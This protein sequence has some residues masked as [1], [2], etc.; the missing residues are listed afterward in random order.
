MQV[1]ENVSIL[2]QN[3]LMEGSHNTEDETS[4]FRGSF[5]EKNLL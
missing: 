4:M 1:G 2:L 5:T 3:V